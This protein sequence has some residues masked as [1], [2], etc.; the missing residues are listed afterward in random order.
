MLSI[1]VL[2]CH[3]TDEHLN[4]A[5]HNAECCC[6]ERLNAVCLYAECR[7]DECR[8]AECL[9]VNYHLSVKRRETDL[10]CFDSR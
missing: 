1:L 6:V 10:R 8:Y 2:T 4:I 3:Y 5:C 9:N 7:N